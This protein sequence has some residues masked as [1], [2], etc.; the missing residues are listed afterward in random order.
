VT[1]DPVRVVVIDDDNMQ[2]ELVERALSRE[3]FDVRCVDTLEKLQ[4]ISPSFLPHIVL[5]DMNMPAISS[6]EAVATARA[7]APNARIVIYS[8]WE[9]SR[10]RLMAQQLG[11][12][13]YVSKSEPVFAIG[14]RLTKLARPSSEGH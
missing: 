10:L 2:L 13:G 1:A 9:E 7:A 3:G 12:D 4:S 8:A 14:G 11:A 5:V 6:G